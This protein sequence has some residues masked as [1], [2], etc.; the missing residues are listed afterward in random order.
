LL[1]LAVFASLA[2]FGLGGSSAPLTPDQERQSF[3]LADANLLIELVA[4]E[5]DVVSPVALSWDEDGRLFVAEMT[6]YPTAATGGRIKLLEDRDGDGKYERVTVFADQ[7]PFP[8]G[9]LPWKGGVLVTAAPN[10]WYCRDR[11]GDGRADERRVLLTGFGEGNPQLRVNGLLWGLD[12]WVYGANGRSDGQA[13][14]PEAPA[15]KG[16]SIRRRDFRFRPETGEVEAV[17]GFSQFGLARDDWGRRFPSWNTVPMRHVVLEERYLSRN[18]AL[19][20]TSSVAPILDPADPGRLYSLSPQPQTFNR[21]PVD[22]FNASCGLTLYRGGQLGAEYAGNA[23]VCEPLTSL[24]HRRV[25]A[26]AGPTFLAK[27]V[28]QGQEF[29]AATDPWFHPVNLATGP[30]GALYVVDFY[31]QWVEHPQ[32]VPEKLRP[33]IDFR[34]GWEHGRIWRIRR[35]GAERG[36]PPR[37]GKATAADLVEQLGHANGWWRDTAQRLLVERQDRQAISLLQRS[38]RQADSPLARAH[39]LWVLHSL[40]A[41]EDDVLRAALRDPHPGVREQALQLAEGLLKRSAA[42]GGAV[43]ALADDPDARVRFQCALALGER[44]DPDALQ[45]LARLAQR[46]VAGEWLRLAVLSSLGETAWPFLQVLLEQCPEWLTAPAAEPARFLAQV[47]ALVGAGPREADLA[48]LLEQ[49]TRPTEAVRPGQLALLAGLAEGLARKGQ[50]LSALLA[51]PPAALAGPLRELD[52]LLS[53]A[54][55]LAA[56]DQQPDAHRVL[57]LQVLTQAQPGVVGPLLLELLRPGQ[58]APVQTA[59]A[60]SLAVVADRVLARRVLEQWNAYTI[61]TRRGILASLLRSAEPASAVVEAIE[62]EQLAAAELDAVARDALRRIPSPDLQRRARAVLLP[63]RTADRQEV[64]RRYQPALGLTGNRPRGAELFVQHC[65]TCHVIQGQGQRVGPDLSSTG[66]RPKEALLTDLLDPSKEI[67]PDFMGYVLVTARGQVLTGLLAAETAT[68]VK[69]RRA[70]GAE[71]TVLRTQIQE[72][73]ATGKSLMPDGLEQ[74]LTL[75][76]MAD[77]LEFLRQPVALPSPR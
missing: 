18:L 75:Q 9:V 6:D 49:L 44:A 41:L 14:R 3:R 35:P 34:K 37:L 38:A 70:E 67:A 69:L 5:P 1:V 76:D 52:Q 4:A 72:L 30:D 40:Q 62:Q 58:P 66:S 11:D 54:R 33:D 17:A 32:Y 8:N 31:R 2:P 26:P 22:Y 56:S 47:A 45:A 46:D 55:A 24:V 39:S 15:P 27:R 51:R 63:D 7:L 25:L 68:S 28:E 20:E 74:T 23:F 65:R 61:P 36:P 42:L 16:V 29:L 43:R 77:L 73:R 21:E 57:A 53:K 48:A 12:N 71:E 10:I 50:P 64:L 19:A 59:A 60:R 13:R